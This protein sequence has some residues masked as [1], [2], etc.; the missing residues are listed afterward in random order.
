MT[1]W[2][3]LKAQELMLTKK[4]LENFLPLGVLGLQYRLISAVNAIN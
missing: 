3:L 1:F 2:T 4:A